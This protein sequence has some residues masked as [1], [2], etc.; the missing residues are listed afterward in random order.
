MIDDVVVG[1]ARLT[2]G[3]A[4][5]DRALSAANAD[6]CTRLVAV[7]R[8]R[9]RAGRRGPGARDCR[10][11]PRVVCYARLTPTLCAVFYV[12]HTLHRLVVL[13]RA[14]Q[15]WVGFAWIIRSTLSKTSGCS[16][17]RAVNSFLPRQCSVATVLD[18][19]VA[20]RAAPVSSDACGTEQRP[21][22]WNDDTGTRAHAACTHESCACQ[23]RVEW[24]GGGRHTYLAKDIPRAERRIAL[25]HSLVHDL[26]VSARQWSPT[27]ITHKTRPRISTGVVRRD[28]LASR[29]VGWQY[30]HARR[31]TP[32]RPICLHARV[33]AVAA[34]LCA[35]ACPRR[36]I[37]G[38]CG[39]LV[40]PRDRS[41]PHTYCAIDCLVMRCMFA[42][43]AVGGLSPQCFALVI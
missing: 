34:E 36:G 41:L 4:S 33:S 32:D 38:K 23:G 42:R 9:V 30:S 5:D 3:T 43:H 26:R 35:C 22:L 16:R 11:R 40:R 39:Q 7:M 28:A 6:A 24:V 17:S 2:P 1:T 25:D 20:L 10:R 18:R 15:A 37:L 8:V 12:C 14:A 19:T 21:Y 27:A 13:F 31:D 29:G